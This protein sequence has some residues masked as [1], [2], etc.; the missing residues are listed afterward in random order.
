MLDSRSEPQQ[1]SI[2]QDET[3]GMVRTVVLRECPFCHRPFEAKVLSREQADS[4]EITKVADSPLETNLATGQVMKGG[5]VMRQGSLFLGLS[6]DERKAVAMR[7]EAFIT[8]KV[9]YHCNHCGKE[10]VKA[11]V[12][13]K[14]LPREYVVDDEEKT[15]YDAHVEQEEAREEEYAR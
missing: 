5:F 14:Q 8:Y 6:E 12:E 7:P 10:W 11:Q 4:S 1:D 2:M 9:T 3:V 13:E 15:D